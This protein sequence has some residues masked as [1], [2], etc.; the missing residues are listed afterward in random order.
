MSLDL[1]QTLA[2]AAVVAVLYF[3]WTGRHEGYQD[4]NLKVIPTDLSAN[5]AAASLLKNINTEITQYLKPA[6]DAINRLVALRPKLK[7]DKTLI[8]TQNTLRKIN[9][10]SDAA[11]IKMMKMAEALPP[12]VDIYK[13][14]YDDL[15]HA[16]INEYEI[17][18]TDAMASAS[19]S[20]SGFLDM[21]Q[22]KRNPT[23][24]INEYNRISN[25][26]LETLADNEEAFKKS[27]E[28]FEFAFARLRILLGQSK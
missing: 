8:N 25:T 4:T 1:Y 9:A 18:S 22:F 2:A 21:D 11:A 24:T 5:D 23:K 10:S 26:R 28:D 7:I 6:V 13:A 3:I 15:T 14:T 16:A 12:K 19:A 20:I 27:A 17:V